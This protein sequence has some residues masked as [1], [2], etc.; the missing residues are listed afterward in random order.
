VAVSVLRYWFD[1]L[2]LDYKIFPSLRYGEL[3][4]KMIA[5]GGYPWTVIPIE[6][7]A[8]IRKLWSRQVQSRIFLRF[9]N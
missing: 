4:R 6:K 5:S 1:S 3:I 2:F 7:R 8:N 9:L